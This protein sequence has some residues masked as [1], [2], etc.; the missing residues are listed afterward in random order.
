MISGVELNW[1]GPFSSVWAGLLS[2]KLGVGEAGGLAVR[3]TRRPDPVLLPP[4]D[5]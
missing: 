4:L 3:G 1:G 2:E 5:G